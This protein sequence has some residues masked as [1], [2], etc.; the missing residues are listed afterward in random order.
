MFKELDI[1][2]GDNPRNQNA[3]I[4]DLYYP[5]ADI[6]HD[7]NNIPYPFKDNTFDIVYLSH[8]LEHLDIH[9]SDNFKKIMREIIRITKPSGSIKIWTPY[10]A[11]LAATWSN[12]EHRR[13]FVYHS[14]DWGDA[15]KIGQDSH[16]DNKEWYRMED[17]W[18]VNKVVLRFGR[19]YKML[20]VQYLANKFSDIYEHFLT[21]FFQARSVEYELKKSL[22]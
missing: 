17:L 14:F 3:I 22:K 1:G 9:L 21:G 12:P 7:A 16:I 11:S 15:S 5:N 6:K 2:G 20:G 13:P 8:V 4:M 19:L 10:A 18:K